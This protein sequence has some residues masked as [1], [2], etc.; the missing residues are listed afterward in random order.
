[1]QGP[2]NQGREFCLFLESNG[3]PSEVFSEGRGGMTSFAFGNYQS[4]CSVDNGCE[5]FWSAFW[6]SAGY[7]RMQQTSK[8]EM[9]VACIQEV[10]WDQKE[11]SGSDRSMGT[12]G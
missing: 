12:V 2:L 1:M 5:G 6:K 3:R 4:G 10:G 9:K 11:T 8:Q 7:R